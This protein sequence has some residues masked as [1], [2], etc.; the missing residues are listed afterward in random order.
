MD[1]IVT[2]SSLPL[3]AFVTPEKS[4]FLFD[5]ITTSSRLYISSQFP[6]RLSVRTTLLLTPADETVIV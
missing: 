3:I 5:V 4:L 1:G 6:L 2:V